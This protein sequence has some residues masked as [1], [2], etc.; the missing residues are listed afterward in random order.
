M[1]LNLQTTVPWTSLVY[2]RDPA[3]ESRTSIGITTPQ[4]AANLEHILGA[5]QEI[6]N[7]RACEACEG[8]PEDTQKTPYES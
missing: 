1:P 4:R 7:Q 6:S 5:Q 3:G 8:H 2:K